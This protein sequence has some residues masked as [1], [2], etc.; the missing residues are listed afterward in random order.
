MLNLFKGR[1]ISPCDS[2]TQDNPS[3]GGHPHYCALKVYR[4]FHKEDTAIDPGIINS[5]L[6]AWMHLCNLHCFLLHAFLVFGLDLVHI[7]NTLQRRSV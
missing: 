4:T 3:K 7:I 5:F 6:L 1:E 2:I